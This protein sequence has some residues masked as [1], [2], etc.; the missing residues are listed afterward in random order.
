MNDIF[1]QIGELLNRDNQVAE[2]IYSPHI[3]ELLLNFFNTA[4]DIVT[5]Y[6]TIKPWQNGEGYVHTFYWL[7]DDYMDVKK[8]YFNMITF[9]AMKE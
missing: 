9:D 1:E 2:N 5:F 7:C 3:V 8:P 4:E 6:W